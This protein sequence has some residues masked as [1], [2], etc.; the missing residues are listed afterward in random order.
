METK[1]HYRLHKSSLLV[2]IL[3]RMH[4]VNTF[5]PYLSQIILILSSHLRLVL[6][7]GFFATGFPTKSF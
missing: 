2:P 6:Q 7:S 1:A 3:S 4:P 5:P